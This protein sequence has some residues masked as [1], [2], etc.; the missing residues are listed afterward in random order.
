MSSEYCINWM[1]ALAL[2][3]YNT[4]YVEAIEEVKDTNLDQSLDH[5]VVLD[6]SDAGRAWDEF[7]S[8]G[9]TN[10]IKERDFSRFPE[11]E[12]KITEKDEEAYDLLWLEAEMDK[13]YLSCSSKESNDNLAQVEEAKNSHNVVRRATKKQQ[14]AK[15]NNPAQMT[16]Y[17]AFMVHSHPTI[18]TEPC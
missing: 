17:K 14:R 13:Y 7:K 15:K 2:I 8:V 11:P 5:R 3:D 12:A 9:T 16:A 10:S 6:E 18:T 4:I 1:S